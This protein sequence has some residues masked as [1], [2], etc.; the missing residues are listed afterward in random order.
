MGDKFEG[1]KIGDRKMNYNANAVRLVTPP[2]E[3]ND[4]GDGKV[5][6]KR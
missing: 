4:R 2:E 5:G 1:R 6:N 3:D